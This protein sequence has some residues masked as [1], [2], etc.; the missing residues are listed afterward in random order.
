M[1]DNEKTHPW[2]FWK[3]LADK[4]PRISQKIVEIQLNP[5]KSMPKQKH[6]FRNCF[7]Y[8]LEGD[9]MVQLEFAKKK[10]A[11]YL[12]EHDHFLVPSEIWYQT[13]NIGK[14]PAFLLEIQYGDKCDAND[15]Q[16]KT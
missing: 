12:T 10:D 6:T 16:R 8:I 14:K 15:Y 2:G 4:Q 13:S 3:T 9:I 1:N 5:G 11:I 7:W